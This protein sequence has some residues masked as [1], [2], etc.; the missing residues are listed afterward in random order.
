MALNGLVLHHCLWSVAE[1][2]RYV[3]VERTFSIAL[4]ERE[5]SVAGRFADDIHRS[6]LAV[7]NL[8][9]VVEVLF[10]DENAHA[11]LRLVGNYLLGAERLVAYWQLCHVD[12]AATFAYELAQAVEVTG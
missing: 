7:G 3:E 6:T 2:L 12:A 8:F 10:V 5:V 4:N 11:L 9:H 1:H